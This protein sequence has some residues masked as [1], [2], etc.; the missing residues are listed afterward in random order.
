MTTKKFMTIF[1]SLILAIF[2][3]A[4]AASSKT[5]TIKL[6]H[7]DPAVRLH[8]DKNDPGAFGASET[9]AQ[10][11]KNMVELKSGKQMVV[12]VYPN[13]Q[14]GAE[15]E[16]FQSVQGGHHSDNPWPAEQPL[17]ALSLNIWLL[18]YPTLF[19]SFEIMK[20]ALEGPL[21]KEFNK[22]I[23]EK[24]GVRVLAWSY[25]GQ[26]HFTNSVRP[27]KSPADLK[28]LKIRVTETPDM[29][30]MIESMGAQA[31]P[32]NYAELYTSLQ[33]GVV[34]GEE[35]PYSV[36]ELIKI[37]EVQKFV[38]TDGHRIGTIPFTINEKFFQFPVPRK[39]E[40]TH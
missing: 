27:I 40:D 32:I 10:V 5:I 16:Q 37:Y 1:T 22:K 39:Q 38:T 35:N 30:K 9:A 15:A 28:G 2:L 21:G 31:V 33:Q 12:K 24:M 34:D 36:L 8:L 7:Q 26:R 29:I 11:F 18:P 25:F 20:V 23:I 13:N 4:P 6:A 3:V 17:G 19:E 14:L